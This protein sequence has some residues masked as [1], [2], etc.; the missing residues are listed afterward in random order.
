[1]TPYWVREYLTD[2]TGGVDSMALPSA[3]GKPGLSRPL[4]IQLGVRGSLIAAFAVIGGMAVVISI[5]ASMLL[6]HSA[7]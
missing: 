6:G 2:L 3:V 1:M 7:R 5:S 4:R